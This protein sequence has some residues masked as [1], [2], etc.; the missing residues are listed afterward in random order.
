LRGRTSSLTSREGPTEGVGIWGLDLG[1]R[2]WGLRLGILEGLR[3]R[4]SSVKGCRVW[5]LVLGV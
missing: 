5:G 3:G 2:V 4:A 1:C